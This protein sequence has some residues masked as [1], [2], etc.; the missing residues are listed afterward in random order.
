MAMKHEHIAALAIFAGVL[1]LLIGIRFVL[2]PEG[3]AKTFGVPPALKGNE[4]HYIIGLRDIWL[5]ALAVAFAILAE[6]RALA[7]WFF[8]AV[9]VCWA[10]AAIVASVG[11]PALAITFHIV[12]G[13]YCLLLG[14]AASRARGRSS[15][16]R[17]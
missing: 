16:S 12:A 13:V 7:L 17:R 3:A 11:G 10:D 14:I 8:L 15:P 6:W 5:G 4:L 1:L 9:V 2:V